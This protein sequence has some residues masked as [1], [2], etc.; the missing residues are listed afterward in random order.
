MAQRLRLRA[1]QGESTHSLRSTKTT[2]E[3]CQPL[4]TE[5]LRFMPSIVTDKSSGRQHASG[6]RHGGL[7]NNFGR[8]FV[9]EHAADPG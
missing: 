5:A 6:K 9:T 4:I 8:A 1:N 7:L 2:S 3:A